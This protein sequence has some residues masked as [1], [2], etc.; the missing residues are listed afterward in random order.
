MHWVRS[1][2]RDQLIEARVDNNKDVSGYDTRIID[3]VVGIGHASPIQEAI[4]VVK[5]VI[6]SSAYAGE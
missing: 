4:E 6:K 3:L 5:N 2:M 1:A